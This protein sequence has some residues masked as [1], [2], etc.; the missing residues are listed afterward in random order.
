M[1]RTAPQLIQKQ[2]LDG[3]STGLKGEIRL[4]L[5]GMLQVANVTDAVLM[6]EITDLMLSQKAHE[7]K[8]AEGEVS[9]T[10]EI[11]A[12]EERSRQAKN[13]LMAQ[14]SKISADIQN[15]HSQTQQLIQPQIDDLRKQL[16][17]QERVFS[18]LHLTPEQ[19]RIL[20]SEHPAMLPVAGLPPVVSGPAPVYTCYPTGPN[21]PYVSPLPL[22]RG[23]GTSVPYR[24]GRGGGQF[25]W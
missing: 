11:N 19:R 24:G 13:P 10:V 23:G 14:M 20:M 18:M 25:V 9:T 12:I 21:Q 4:M 2:F 6:K 8:T 7:N 22:Q 16:K 15:I 17:M 3:L 1:L 5:Q